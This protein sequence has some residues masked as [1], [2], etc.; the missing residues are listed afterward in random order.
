MTSTSGSPF[1][2]TRS[3]NGINQINVISENIN[4][5]QYKLTDLTYNDL[6]NTTTI[7]NNTV[8]YDVV[9]NGTFNASNLSIGNTITLSNGGVMTFIDDGQNAQ[10]VDTVHNQTIGGH[11]NFASAEIDT[12]V[13]ESFTFPDGSTQTSSNYLTPIQVNATDRITATNS[14][15]TDQLT[16]VDIY[17]ETINISNK[18]IDANNTGTSPKSFIYNSST[19]CYKDAIVN[20]SPLIVQVGNYVKSNG[21]GLLPTGDSGITIATIDTT[22]RNMTFSAGGFSLTI[23][24]ASLVN[25]LCAITSTNTFTSYNSLSGYTNYGIR[26]VGTSFNQPF[27]NSLTGSYNATTPTTSLTYSPTTKA[28]YINSS[29]R[30]VS[31]NTYPNQNFISMTGTSNPAYI[32]A[33]FG[34]NEYTILSRN[35]ITPNSTTGSFLAVP[36]S[37]TTLAYPTFAGANTDFI[38]QLN[39]ISAGT[40]STNDT[41]TGVLTLSLSHT[42]PTPTSIDVSGYVRSNSLKLESATTIPIDQYVIGRGTSDN[43]IIANINTFISATPTA[44]SSTY[45]LRSGTGTYTPINTLA[46]AGILGYVRFASS[47]YWF[48]S[49]TQQQNN[50]FIES[51]LTIPQCT[52]MITP[53]APY[54]GQTKIMEL[55]QVNGYLPTASTP[56]YTAFGMVSSTTIVKLTS[57]L[58][59]FSGTHILENASSFNSLIPNG[60]YAS[61]YNST[62]QELTSSITLTAQTASLTNLKGYLRTT[63]LLEIRGLGNATARL[64]Y[65]FTGSGI[66]SAKNYVSVASSRTPFT[67]A[68][69]NTATTATAT[70]V[71]GF[72]KFRNASSFLLVIANSTPFKFDDYLISSTALPEN[73]GLSAG[74]NNAVSSNDIIVNADFS[75][76]NLVANVTIREPTISANPLG[77]KAYPVTTSTYYCLQTITLGATNYINSTKADG[78]SP[79]FARDLCLRGTPNANNLF[80]TSSTLGTTTITTGF[81]GAIFNGGGGNWYFC[82]NNSTNLV[83][84][85]I[86]G[87]TIAPDTS[88]IYNSDLFEKGSLTMSKLQF[89]V[90]PVATI[91]VTGTA[92][93]TSWY[94]RS[95]STDLGGGIFETELYMRTATT[96]I[97]SFGP[98]FF[99]NSVTAT[100]FNNSGL[101]GSY[102]T[103]YTQEATLNCL[104]ATFRGKTNM[105]ATTQKG[106]DLGIFQISTLV[107]RID[108]LGLYVPSV[109]DF[110]RIVGQNNVNN[111]RAVSSLGSNLYD[112]TLEYTQGALGSGFSYV[113]TSPVTTTA[114]LLPTTAI[115]A[116]EASNLVVYTAG[117]TYSYYPDTNL[118]S[119][120]EPISINLFNQANTAF[121]PIKYTI[122]TPFTYN[123]ITPLTITDF[124]R[125]TLSF[126]PTETITYYTFFDINLPPNQANTTLVSVDAIQV[127]TNK[128]F[129]APKINGTLF[130]YIDWTAI[131]SRDA[132]GGSALSVAIAGSGGQVPV[133]SNA[134][135]CR[136]RYY[137]SVVGKTM[138]LNYLYQATTGIAQPAGTYYYRYR[139]PAGFTY[140]SWL[141]SAG[142]SPSFASGTRLGSARL[143]VNGNINYCSVYYFAT[144]S[145]RFLYITR[146]QT[147][148]DYHGSAN[149]TYASN[150]NCFTFEASL[151]LA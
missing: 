44:P 23:P 84:T 31:L 73:T 100:S 16:A 18:I 7:T 141:V 91:P 35:A 132:S 54:V 12:L 20:N 118:Y 52:R 45:T 121:L 49:W 125:T 145:D 143:N 3:M 87:T 133:A 82:S 38:T 110:I 57:N 11:K 140:P 28:G 96:R 34:T 1:Y 33:T 29:Q 128:D 97:T 14:M 46:T 27:I 88:V 39:N 62:N 26:G 130:N 136:L 53:T 124:S 150:N 51:T 89:R 15:E 102:I 63:S 139:L 43:G 113:I 138:Y 123:Y 126:Y 81:L 93:S 101:N 75:D 64:N 58:A 135:D 41:A 8:L 50:Y 21:I 47:K 151:P 74:L 108:T 142:T 61:S 10:V 37:N 77:Y 65:F 95:N 103:A 92:I 149:Y 147:L 30:L 117:S 116:Y 79:A 104:K 32:S 4:D 131:A 99:V 19:M 56:S 107:Y 127:L 48:I 148:F 9:I 66:G 40:K 98:H 68:S 90:A 22:N 119:A 42:A 111:I 80:T 137:Y 70:G 5:L 106:G 122:Q 114:S 78:I 2:T 129:T 112:L 134:V 120:F 60:A 17:C 13:I 24:P 86:V 76:Y 94:I 55:T 83:D 146:E 67:L 71:A 59:S 6:T 109:N 105:V 36:L 144:G 25:T 69:T 72:T 115:T 85:F